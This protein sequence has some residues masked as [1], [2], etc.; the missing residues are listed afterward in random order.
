MISQEF[1][2]T[3]EFIFQNTSKRLLNPFHVTGLFL[4]SLKTS[5]YLRFSDVFKG[6]RKRQVAWNGLIQILQFKANPYVSNFALQDAV[7]K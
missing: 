4:Y 6:Y 7:C 1:I 3:S 2:E 5:E